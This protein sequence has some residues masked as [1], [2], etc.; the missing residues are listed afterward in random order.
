MWL[1]ALTRLDRTTLQVGL[2]KEDDAEILGRLDDEM[3]YALASIVQH[4]NLSFDE[5]R[6][7]LNTTLDEA[8]HVAR[9]LM[10]YGFVEHKHNDARRITLAPRFH[11]Q[12][13]RALLGRNL[14]MKE[15]VT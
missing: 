5:L 1:G 2:I 4:E 14:L 13:L 7:S 15:D 11:Q 8:G 12:V 3:L 10:E 9:F 6:Q